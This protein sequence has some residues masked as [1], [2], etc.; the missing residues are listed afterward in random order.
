MRLS[1]PAFGS[2]KSQ[3]KPRAVVSRSVWSLAWRRF[4]YNR[5]ARFPA[6]GCCCC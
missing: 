3:S 4:A 1:I 2:N 6:W 5:L